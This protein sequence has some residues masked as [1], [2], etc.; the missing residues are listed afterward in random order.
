MNILITGAT[1]MIGQALVSHLSKQHQLTLLGRTHEKITQLFSN[2]YAILTWDDLNSHSEDQLKNIDII[3][4][5]AGENIGEKRWSYD[6]KQKILNSRVTATKAI[7]EL[8]ASLGENAPRILNAGGVGIYGFSKESDPANTY[9]TEKST[10]SMNPDCFLTTVGNAWENALSF[11]EKNNVKTVK[12]RFGV[13]LSNQG[14]AL[15]KMLPAFRFGL[16]AVLGNG[17]QPFSWVVLDDLV[18]AIDFIISKPDI[19]GAVN[20]VSP[21]VTTQ[22]DFAKSLARSLHRPCFLRMPESIVRLL[23]GEMGNELLLKGQRVKSEQLLQMGFQF[24]YTQIDQALQ[25]LFMGKK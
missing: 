24:Q 21:G 14:G 3:V 20:I 7:S 23:F 13:V 8:C 4:N 1:G 15:Q 25:F 6:Q 22:G 16:G 19:T 9:F 2:R 17:K 10:I 12:M 11:A 18:R 5:L